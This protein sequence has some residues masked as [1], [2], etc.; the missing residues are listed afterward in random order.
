MPRF[1][2]ERT[3][4][5]SLRATKDIDIGESAGWRRM[6]G[7]DDLV[8]LALAAV[9][10]AVHFEGARIAD[11][12]Q[13]APERRRNPTVVWILYHALPLSVLDQLAPLAAELEFIARVVDRPGNVGA[14]Q[15]AAL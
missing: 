13:A 14:H 7:V 2:A 3:I 1:V 6:S 5:L 4:L 8:G 9:L 15:E 11:G 12:A 10:R